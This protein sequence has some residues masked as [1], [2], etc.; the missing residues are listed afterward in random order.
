MDRRRRQINS[1]GYAAHTGDEFGDLEPHQQTTVTGL[2]TLP[3]F[4]FNGG[5][6]ALHFRNG[7]NNFIPAEIARGNLQD[8]IFQ[9]RTLQDPGRTS[10]FTGRHNNGNPEHL[11]TVG[12]TLQQSQPHIG[13][14]RP[15]GHRSYDK[16][17]DIPGRRYPFTGGLAAQIFFRRQHPTKNGIQAELMSSGIKRRIGKHGD[18]VK[19]NPIKDSGSGFIPA[20]APFPGLT[21]LV[22]V[23][24]RSMLIGVGHRT[25]GLVGTDRGTHAAADTFF[26]NGCM[27]TDTDKM[28]VFIA[29][30]LLKNI[31]FGYPLP[32]VGQVDGINRTDSRTATA[33]RAAILPVL[34]DPGQVAVG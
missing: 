9:E 12:N 10:A 8:D 34:N 25:N 30:L 14:K 33:K 32:P 28:P 7:T 29:P 21:L 16:G 6:I 24:N 19:G 31:K 22:L 18:A 1:L 15:K 5:G 13:R 23:K 20:T 27:L 26:F 3:V 4:D 11:I 17:E 2:G